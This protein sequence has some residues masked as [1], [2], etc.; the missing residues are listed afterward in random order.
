MK[1][2]AM[3]T[4]VALVLWQVYGQY[5]AG[6]LATLMPS[7]PSASATTGYATPPA[8]GFR[9]DRRTHCAQMTSCAEA[10]FFQKNCRDAD[11]EVDASGLPCPRRWCTSPNA[12]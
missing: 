8:D 4:F 9:C 10:K 3:L 2:V 12:P 1:R 6:R 5:K 7:A 11:L